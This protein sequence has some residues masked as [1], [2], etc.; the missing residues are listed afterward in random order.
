MEIEQQDIV[1]ALN[2]TRDEPVLNASPPGNILFGKVLPEEVETFG[3]D[4]L[5]FSEIS[6]ACE[7]SGLLEIWV[8]HAP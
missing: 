3:P 1:F 5:E 4:S 8:D 7:E 2:Y 6:A